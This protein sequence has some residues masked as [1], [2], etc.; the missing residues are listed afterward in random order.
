MVGGAPAG[1]RGRISSKQGCLESGE[2]RS[3]PSKP[4][5][6]VVGWG[7]MRVDLQR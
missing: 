5:A 3:G 7:W 4:V 1:N 6:M 2:T